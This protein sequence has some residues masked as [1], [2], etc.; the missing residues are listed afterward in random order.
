MVW[1]PCGSGVLCRLF[2]IKE[3]ILVMHITYKMV[4][5]L[6]YRYI[7]GKQTLQNIHDK[8]SHYLL[9]AL[10]VNMHRLYY[11]VEDAA[12]KLHVTKHSYSPDNGNCTDHLV[13]V[14]RINGSAKFMKA[15]CLPHDSSLKR[16]L[17]WWIDNIDTIDRI[18]TISQ[19]S[20]VLLFYCSKVSLLVCLESSSI[21]SAFLHMFISLPKHLKLL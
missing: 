4:N 6:W 16:S 10:N 1:A 15:H 8:N 7:E 21:Q 17:P 13:R 2:V 14:A 5:I 11:V 19:N 18:D 12:L 3:K 9:F 20:I